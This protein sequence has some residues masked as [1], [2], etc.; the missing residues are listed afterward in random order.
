M[1]PKDYILQRW[2]KEDDRYAFEV[3]ARVLAEEAAPF[4]QPNDLDLPVQLEPFLKARR[5]EYV[6]E[7]LLDARGW[8]ISP[9]EGGFLLLHRRELGQRAFRYISAHEVAHTLFFDLG[10]TY[11]SRAIPY[12]RS[13]EE[14]MCHQIARAL[15]MPQK[16][17]K[18]S[19]ALLEK[20]ADHEPD[21][22][23]EVLD[24]LR[25]LIKTAHE[26]FQIPFWR[27]LERFH[28]LQSPIWSNLAMV[29]WGN[30]G[31]KDEK[32]RTFL[33]ITGLISKRGIYIPKRKKSED[34]SIKGH[35][36][37]RLP[38]KTWRN[39]EPLLERTPMDLGTLRGEFTSFTIRIEETQSDIHSLE[40]YYVLHT[41]WAEMDK[42]IKPRWK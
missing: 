33:R 40:S 30:P 29:R 5:I 23:Q 32:G 17:L 8:K 4:R 26:R 18:G 12:H 38:L 19:S 39:G 16:H 36:K 1:N 9:R 22:K 35:R 13:M 28:D 7:N 20:L 21:T 31:E 2:G 24:T 14:K 27:F 42:F 34:E 11:P 10:D 3:A 15:L 41:I 25:L 37:I 6:G